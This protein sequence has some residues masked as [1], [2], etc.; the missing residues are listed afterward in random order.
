[1]WSTLGSRTDKKQNRTVTTPVSFHRFKVPTAF[2]MYVTSCDFEK[3][4][5]FD[6]LLKIESHMRY[7]VKAQTQCSYYILS[8]CM[9]VRMGSN[10]KS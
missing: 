9:G 5:I 6:E 3:A 7:S 2:A 1:M 8:R 10:S 4:F